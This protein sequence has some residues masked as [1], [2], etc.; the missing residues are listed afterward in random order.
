MY[1]GGY[2]TEEQAALAY[3]IAAIRYRGAEAHTNYALSNYALEL[4]HL[5]EVPAPPHLV[6]PSIVCV[7]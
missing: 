1:L 7:K 6:P 3:D 2:D 5:P 4:K